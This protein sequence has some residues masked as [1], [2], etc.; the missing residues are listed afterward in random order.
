MEEGAGEMNRGYNA[1]PMQGSTTFSKSSESM[2]SSVSEEHECGMEDDDDFVLITSS[3]HRVGVLWGWI[4][5]DKG[6]CRG[7]QDQELWLIS[8]HF[9]RYLIFGCR[10]SLFLERK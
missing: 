2:T 7:I 4:E 9:N 5:R 1:S 3:G 10:K 6:R 8:F